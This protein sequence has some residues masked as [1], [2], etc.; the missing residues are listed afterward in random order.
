MILSQ[1]VRKL[2]DWTKIRFGVGGVLDFCAS[3]D[4]LLVAENYLIKMLSSAV[5]SR[6]HKFHKA[7]FKQQQETHRFKSFRTSSQKR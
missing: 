5:A 2:D 4:K 6:Q 7:L 1:T 3:N